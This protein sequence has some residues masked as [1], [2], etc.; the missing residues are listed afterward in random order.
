[1][2]C[3]ISNFLNFAA[4]SSCWYN[5]V[6]TYIRSEY[7]WRCNL[8]IWC[9][10]SVTITN[11]LFISWRAG[12]SGKRNWFLHNLT[13]KTP[14][15]ALCAALKTKHSF[16]FYYFPLNKCIFYISTFLQVKPCLFLYTGTV[17]PKYF[18]LVEYFCYFMKYLN[19]ELI[20][21]DRASLIF[22]SKE[23]FVNIIMIKVSL[24]I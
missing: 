2:E 16:V 22:Y 6:R 19:D 4:R 10:G 23:D 9:P 15:R 7:C 17:E 8:E 24:W 21:F 1:M 3:E 18:S 20:T 5:K 12:S 14:P 13:P 11:V